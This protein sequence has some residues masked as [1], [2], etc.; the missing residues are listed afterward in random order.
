[1]EFIN[2]DAR[3]ADYSEGTVFFMFTPFRGEISGG[4]N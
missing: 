3:Q 1:V 4:I 2:V